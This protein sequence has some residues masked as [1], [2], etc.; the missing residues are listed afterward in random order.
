MMGK[1]LDDVAPA[2]RGRVKFI[3]VCLEGGRH[4]SF[5][6]VAIACGPPAQLD[7]EY[8]AA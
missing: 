5:A 3:K 6:A 2:M 1:I 8:S 7:V 4:C